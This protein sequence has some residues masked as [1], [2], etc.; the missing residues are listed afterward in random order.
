MAQSIKQLTFGFGSGH[1]LTVGEIQPWSG[2]AL[3]VWSLLGIFSLPL[4]LPLPGLCSLSLKINKLKKN[5]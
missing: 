5:R 4:S 3:T 1:G 2:S